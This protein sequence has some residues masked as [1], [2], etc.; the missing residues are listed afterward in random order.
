MTQ[1]HNRFIIIAVL[2]LFLFTSITFAD[3]LL[4]KIKPNDLNKISYST[5]DQCN[6]RFQGKSYILIQGDSSLF[7]SDIFTVLDIAPTEH[8]YYMIG[9]K[10]SRTEIERIG[11]IILESEALSFFVFPRQASQNLSVW[12]SRYLHFPKV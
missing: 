7:D 4:V 9:S 3:D 8:L 10:Q 2:A 11:K 6:I 1:Q 12:D 5:L